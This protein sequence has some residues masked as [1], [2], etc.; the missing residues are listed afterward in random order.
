[1]LA[2]RA[3]HR[4]ASAFKV[5]KGQTAVTQCDAIVN[6]LAFAVGAAVRDDVAHSLQRRHVLFSCLSESADAAH[7]LL[8]GTIWFDSS[9]TS[10][11]SSDSENDIPRHVVAAHAIPI[12]TI[13]RCP[14][15]RAFHRRSRRSRTPS[16]TPARTPPPHACHRLQ[17]PKRSTSRHAARGRP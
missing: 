2:G 12:A 10:N 17:A 8:L 15:S 1:M 4:L 16:R 5:D 6:V 13:H 7:A 9:I 14:R 11:N 3:D